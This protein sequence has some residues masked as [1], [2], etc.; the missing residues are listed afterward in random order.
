MPK[1]KSYEEFVEKF[2]PKKTTDDCYTPP[3]V[4]EAVKD[5]VARRYKLDAN[6]FVR[7]FYP[8]GDYESFEYNEKIVVDNP[9]FSILSKIIDFYIEHDIKFFLFAPTLTLFSTLRDKKCTAILTGVGITY[10]NKA[11]ISTSFITNLESL[12]VRAWTA[13]DLYK[14]VKEANEAQK[15]EKAVHHPKYT[16]PYHVAIA[17]KIY[18]YN[19]Y[20]IEIS[21][22][23]EESVFVPHLDAQVKMKKEIFGG[24]F[25]VSERCK[26]GIEKAEREKAEREKAEREKAE[27]EK[28]IVFELSEREKNLIKTLSYRSKFKE[29]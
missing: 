23:R 27:R 21:I 17:S 29:D 1:S 7:P 20:G 12:E 22:P 5:W 16:Y 19:K 6:N 26:Q 18:S 24:G 4:Y 2:K 28:A 10:E 8:G 14:V 9:P 3:R 15:E 25:L 13:P 11:N